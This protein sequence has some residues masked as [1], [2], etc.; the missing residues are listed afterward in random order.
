MFVAA[1]DGGGTKTHCIIGDIQGNIVSEGIGPGSNYQVLGSE[2]SKN[3][4]KLALESALRK[5]KISLSKISYAT[6]GMSGADEEIDI[7]N[8]SKFV[9]EILIDIPFTIYHDSWIGLRAN[10]S[11]NF[12]IVAICGTGTGYSGRTKSGKEVQLRNMT[13]ETGNKGGGGDLLRDALHFAFRSE[14]GSYKKSSLEYELPKLFRLETMSELYD[15][16]RVREFSIDTSISKEIP[17]LVFRLSSEGDEV[18]KELL[19][20][21]GKTV[22]LYIISVAK[23]LDLVN[24][25]FPVIM[26][27]SIYK[28]EDSIFINTMKNT[29][30]SHAKL[31]KFVIPK[32]EPVYGAYYL[33]LDKYKNI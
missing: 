4:I 1:F 14:E 27:G 9:K 30:L 24:D 21:M 15:L 32:V 26:V 3:S 25:S 8:I 23:K 11:E 31:A 18:C 28:G 13:Y 16:L 6:F 33:A 10:N 17:K 29:V 12:G 2:Y 5:A 7:S 22:G 20:N 19:I